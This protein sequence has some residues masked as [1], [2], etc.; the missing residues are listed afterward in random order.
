MQWRA[1]D[2]LWSFPRPALVMGVVNVTP[3]SFSD[4]GSFQNTKAAIAHGL[5]LID[6]GADIIDVGG[7]STRPGAAPVND[8]EEQRRVIPVIEGLAGKIPVSVDTMKPTVARAALS[9]GAV[10]VNDVA[11]NRTDPEMWES[12]A[13]AKAGYV[14]MHMQGTPQTMQDNPHYENAVHEVN[15]FFDE[16]L[17][18]LNAFGI[19]SD[20][21]VLDVGIGFGKTVE[22]NLQLL[23]AL[24]TFTKWKRPI[25]LGASRK[26]FIGRITGAE[27]PAERVAGSLACA[28]WGIAGGAGIIRA[29]DVAAT[30]QAVRMTESIL[31][32]TQ[33]HD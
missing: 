16:R 3:D 4:G 1:R 11:A 20:Q 14:L 7:E 18:R 8:K 24:K 28:C 12:I 33:R 17:K 23:A 32:S 13:Q 25:L 9:A 30:R 10:I 5:R 6:E 22:H 29:H 21:V 31:Q 19:A 27:Q 15:E 2:Q 26:G